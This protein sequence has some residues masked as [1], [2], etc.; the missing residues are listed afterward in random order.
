MKRR[1]RGQFA[2][3]DSP[4]KRASGFLQD[5]D[6]HLPRLDDACSQIQLRTSDIN[7]YNNVMLL[8]LFLNQSK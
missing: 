4:D 6:R 7:L 2:V 8:L 5:S 3:L 1:S